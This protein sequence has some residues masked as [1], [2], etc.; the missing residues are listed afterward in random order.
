MRQSSDMLLP[1]QHGTTSRCNRRH[2]CP[3]SFSWPPL[4][5]LLLPYLF[6]LTSRSLSL[7]PPPPPPCSW[8]LDHSGLHELRALRDRLMPTWEAPKVP[9]GGQQGNLGVLYFAVCITLGVVVPA[10]RRSRIL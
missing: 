2:I 4:L 5:F 8:A 9:L 10:L 1:W 7:R 3:R 6:P